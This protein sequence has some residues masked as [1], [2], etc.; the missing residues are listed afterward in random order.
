[1]AEHHSARADAHAAA[2]LL[3]RCLSRVAGLDAIAELSDSTRLAAWPRVRVTA[4]P[5][6]RRDSSLR[7][8]VAETYIG[9]LVSRLPRH[10]RTPPETTAYLE[11]L[12]RALEDRRVSES[13]GDALFALATMAGLSQTDVHAAHEMYVRDLIRVALA[14]GL[15]SEPERTDIDEVRTLLGVSE[16]LLRECLRRAEPDA[17][18]AGDVRTREDLRGRTV[19]FTGELI[20]SIDGVRIERPHA[21]HLAA[22]SG[23]TV[24]SG[25]SKKLDL[26]VL[27]DP[28]SMSGKARKARELGI[29]LMA[30]PVFWAK[31]GVRVD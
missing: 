21:E 29:R 5:L 6:V 26:L 3:T 4:R 19:C 13:E 25:V 22:E 7:R 15:L 9:R 27:A 11:L 23:L 18:P 14:D 31:I 24:K 28:D 12:D 1:L 30:E 10:G 17:A 16:E 8:E 20:S 2:A